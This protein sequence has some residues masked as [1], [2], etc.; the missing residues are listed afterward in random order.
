[1]QDSK[2]CPSLITAWKVGRLLDGRVSI[3]T[4]TLFGKPLDGYRPSV[5]VQPLLPR[6]KKPTV[7]FSG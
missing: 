3:A 2:S 5:A 6:S 4:V 7:G 1:M